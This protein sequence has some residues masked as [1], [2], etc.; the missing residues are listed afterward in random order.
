MRDSLKPVMNRD[1]TTL[2]VRASAAASGF[3]YYWYFTDAQAN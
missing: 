1:C 2:I 3:F